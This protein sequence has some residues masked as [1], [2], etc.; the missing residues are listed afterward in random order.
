MNKPI[1]LTIKISDYDIKAID[2]IIMT[3]DGEIDEMDLDYEIGARVRPICQYD[4]DMD[5][6]K[7]LKRLINDARNQN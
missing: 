5:F 1:E 4:A 3:I 6:L 7:K 2:H